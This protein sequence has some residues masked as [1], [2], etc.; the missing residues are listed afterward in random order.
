[1]MIATL[2]RPDTSARSNSSRVATG[3]GS[4][5]PF[6]AKIE[7]SKRGSAPIATY[8]PPAFRNDGA[9]PVTHLTACARGVKPAIKIIPIVTEPDRFMRKTL[10]MSCYLLALHL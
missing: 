3:W 7:L 9:R 4:N 2:T 1:M 6:A 10:F 8:P 5:V